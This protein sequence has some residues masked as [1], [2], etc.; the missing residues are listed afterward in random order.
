M[1]PNKTV[2]VCL[3][4]IGW[5]LLAAT[6]AIYANAPA[7]PHAAD[8]HRDVLIG[9][10]EFP[11]A[12]EEALVWAYGGEV[13]RTFWLVPAMAATMS[14]EAASALKRNPN[15][16]YVEPNGEVYALG[17]TVPWGIDRVH[18]CPPPIVTNSTPL[19]A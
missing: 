5:L 18:G 15:V 9:F 14:D 1:L 10:H 11:G 7:G 2:T 4:V 12:V 16:R 19:P 17:Q 3:G 8:S 13:R 6:P